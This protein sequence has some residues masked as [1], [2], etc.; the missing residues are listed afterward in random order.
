[1]LATLFD[2]PFDERRKLTYWSDLATT[3]MSD[4]MTEDEAKAELLGCAAYFKNLWDVRGA[5]AMTN[6]LI[7]LLA[8]GESTRDM[9][10]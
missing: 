4:T 10:R 5:R 6:D 9:H 7:S 8:H 2:F 3:D 1:M